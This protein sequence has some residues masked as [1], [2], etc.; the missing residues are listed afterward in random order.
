MEAFNELFETW[1]PREKY[2]LINATEYKGKF[3]KHKIY[4]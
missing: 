4:Y 2:Q 1:E 3:L